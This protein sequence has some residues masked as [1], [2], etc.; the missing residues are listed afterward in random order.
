VKLSVTKSFRF[1][2]A[3][4]LP[5][6]DGKCALLHGHSYK[7]EVTLSGPLCDNGMVID[8]GDISRLVAPIIEE[9]DHNY[10][11]RLYYNPTAENMVI[12]IGA[13]LRKQNGLVTRVRLWETETCYAE[14]TY[15]LAEG[16]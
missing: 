1:E 7:L 12:S 3:H 10:L 13:A 9:H 15:D 2:A 11:N 14:V 8:F 5:D 4:Y 16:K 6:Y